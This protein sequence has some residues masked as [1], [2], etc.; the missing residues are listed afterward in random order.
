MVKLAYHV[1]TKLQNDGNRVGTLG[2]RVQKELWS[3]IWRLKLPNKI[4]IFGWRACHAILPTA[5][6][7]TRRKVTSESNCPL[8]LREVETTVHALRDCAVVQDVWAGSFRKLQKWADKHEA[9]D[10]RTVGVPNV[11]WNGS[12]LGSS[13]DHMESGELCGAWW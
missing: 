4:K 10:G 3:A 2:G 7:L 13:M 8:C 11:G 6:N 9:A 12:I 1:A 5:E